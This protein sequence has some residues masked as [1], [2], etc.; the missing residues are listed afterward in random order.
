MSINEFIRLPREVREEAYL[1]ARAKVGDGI[2][3]R[4]VLIRAAEEITAE[5]A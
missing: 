2:L 1:R 4:A 3:R 5:A